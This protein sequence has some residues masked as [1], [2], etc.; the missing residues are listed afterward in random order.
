M[1]DADPDL[2]ALYMWSS[3]H[4]LATLSLACDFSSECGCGDHEWAEDGVTAENLF[5]QFGDFLTE[6]LVPR[7]GSASSTVNH[8]ND[9]SSVGGTGWNGSRGNGSNVDDR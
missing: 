8:G 3:V 1:R 6:G 2:I 9:A 7:N 4:G 5:D